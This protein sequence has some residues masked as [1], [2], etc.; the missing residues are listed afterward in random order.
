MIIDPNLRFP[1]AEELKG[2]PDFLLR[3]QFVEAVDN[4]WPEEW[5][6]RVLDEKNRRDAEFRKTLLMGF[7]VVVPRNDSIF[8][9]AND[10]AV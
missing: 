10:Y 4:E 5:I 9:M 2:F 1:D 8:V 3:E 7:T 6:D